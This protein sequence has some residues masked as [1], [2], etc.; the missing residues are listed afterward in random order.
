M[1]RSARIAAVLVGAAV[2]AALV[3]FY[4]VSWVLSYPSTVQAQTSGG[5]ASLSIETVAAYGHSPHSSWVS[6]F[7]KGS[8][9]R[10]HHSTIIDVPAHTLLHVTIYNFDGKSGLRNPLWAKPRGVQGEQISLNGKSVTGISPDDAS[11]TFAIPD[12]GISVPIQGVGDNAP[13]QCA[14]PAPCPMSTAHT[15]TTF[16][17]RT[18][19]PG[20]YRWQCFVPCA[21]GFLNGFGG[22]MQTVG[23]M[24]GY[25]NVT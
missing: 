19:K 9:G 4:V 17:I 25:L 5:S 21:A 23:Y 10:W 14:T 3:A 8:D 2:V 12:M 24:D 15:V 1:T 22:P 11:H 20:H 18:G 13:N 6:Y 7:V 16:V